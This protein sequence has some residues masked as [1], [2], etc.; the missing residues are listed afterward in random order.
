MKKLNLFTCICSLMLLFYSCS[1]ENPA[2]IEQE[3][4]TAT[5]TFG[6]ILS[7]PGQGREQLRQASA[8][9]PECLDSEPAYVALVLSGTTAVGTMEDPLV[10][11]IISS[12]GK[13]FTMESP[14]LELA[15]GSYN[16]EF[17]AIYDAGD[18]LLWLAPRRGAN[19]DIVG[20]MLP[21]GFELGAGVKKY[22]DINVLCYD[23]KL[24]N[25]Y[26]Y[27]FFEL[28]PTEAIEFCLFGNTCDETGRHAP[29][30][31][32][33]DVWT[34]SGNPS[35]PYGTP[36]FDENEPFI[37]NVGINED[38]DAFA[39]PLCV[40]LPDT[41]GEDIYYGE[42]YL[43]QNGTSTLI[44]SGEFSDSDVRALFE[45]DDR[46][47]YYHFREGNCNMEDQPLLFGN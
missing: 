47:D 45:G 38:G 40:T 22:L 9:L 5:L 46:V 28:N 13:Y 3:K 24:V 44:R 6:A 29:A 8:N 37:N 27:Q 31:F 21:F 43:L 32:R 10:V 26:G 15:P 23:D 12:S 20:T 14:D 16:L 18:N 4:T 33:F 25:L 36:L 42:I 1:K 11:D 39:N 2:L 17:F 7:D 34:Y 30:N 35:N 19:M 41:R